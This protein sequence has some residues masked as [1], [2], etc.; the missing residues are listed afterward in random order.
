VTS[1]GQ[2]APRSQILCGAWATPDDVPEQWRGEEADDQ[3]AS[4]LLQA[5][6]I[7]YKLSGEQWAGVGCSYTAELRGRPPE[8]G[9][10]AYPYYRQWGLSPS[11][12]GYW[13]WNSM[14]GFAWFP[15]YMGLLANPYAVKLPHDQVT[16]IEQVTI[17]GEIFSSWRLSPGGW[18]ERTDGDRWSK[19]FDD[20]LIQYTYGEAAPE[21][22]VAACVELAHELNLFSCGSADCRLPERVTSVSRQGVSI[23]VVDPMDFFKIGRTGLYKVDLWLSAINP[24]S[25]PRRARVFSPDI[26]RAM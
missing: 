21:S 24:A 26:P 1:P 10:G 5:S 13:W 11:G 8:Q 18:L 19:V 20:T 16:A 17:N 15:Q 23:A 2:P 3:W 25:R 14:V 22:G 7:L 4:Y 12:P 6:E 9:S